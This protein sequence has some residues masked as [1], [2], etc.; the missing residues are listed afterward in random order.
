MPGSSPDVSTDTDTAVGHS[1]W[2]SLTDS[3]STFSEISQWHG[4][5]PPL[6]ACTTSDCGDGAAPPAVAAKA[7]RPGSTSTARSGA[8][9]AGALPKA[10]SGPSGELRAGSH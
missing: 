4:P 8:G 9:G 2:L 10:D 5:Q 6:L 7:R 3:Q 1:P